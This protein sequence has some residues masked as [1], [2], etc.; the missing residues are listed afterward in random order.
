MGSRKRTGWH[1]DING[2]NISAL[3]DVLFVGCRC[4]G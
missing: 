2:V 3:L 4:T 1:R